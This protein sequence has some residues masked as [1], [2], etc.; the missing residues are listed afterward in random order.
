MNSAI[1]QTASWAHQYQ[2]SIVVSGLN[3]EISQSMITI[4]GTPC[5]NH[6]SLWLDSGSHDFEFQSAVEINSGKRYAWE[7]SSGLST[8]RS[9]TLFVSESDTLSA[10]YK[11]Q[12]FLNVISPYGVSIGTGWYDSESTAY[13]SL[14][15][16][17]IT[18]SDVRQLFIGWSENA[19]GNNLVSDPILMD[20]PKNATALWK[21]QFLVVFNQTGIPSDSNPSILVDSADYS[22]PCS[23]WADEGTTINFVYPNHIQNGFGLCY[24]LEYPL[25]QS[26][27]VSSSAIITAQYAMEYD[28]TQITLFLLPAILIPSSVFLVYWKRKKQTRLQETLFV[29]RANKH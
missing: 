26:L 3:S 16:S 1:T 2:I 12:F 8:Q 5:E 9:G 29:E 15:R 28:G 23:I 10:N 4:D 27:E 14:N 7:Y 19:S 21:T 13:A 22:L 17:I 11:T 6:A 25:N 18:S 20:N 24:V